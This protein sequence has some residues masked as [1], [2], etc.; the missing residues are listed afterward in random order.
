MSSQEAPLKTIEQ[1][2]HLVMGEH[3]NELRKCPHFKAVILDGYLREKQLASM[4]LL[5]VPQVIAE[6]RRPGVIEDLISG[7]NLQY[8]FK[9]IDDFYQGAKNPILSDEEEAELAELE[10]GVDAEVGEL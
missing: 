3:L 2:H 8:F 4:S 10:N 5:A 1:E 9:M 7:S 6:G